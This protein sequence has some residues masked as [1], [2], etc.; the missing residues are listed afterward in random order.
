VDNLAANKE[1]AVAEVGEER[2]RIWRLYMTASIGAFE[3][4]DVSLQQLLAVVP[5][6]NNPRPL[7]RPSY[8]PS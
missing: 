8:L 5:G 6:A 7:A 1:A 4:T 3:R 2:E